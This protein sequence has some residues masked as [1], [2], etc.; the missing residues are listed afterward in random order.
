MNVVAL[1]P[2]SANP[3]IIKALVA[4]SKQIRSMLALRLANI[5][6]AIGEDDLILAMSDGKPICAEQLCRKIGIS[7][8]TLHRVIQ[9]LVARGY[10]EPAERPLFRLSRKGNESV[11]HI[12][13]LRVQIA[14]E[15][16]AMIGVDGIEK[17]CEFLETIEAGFSHFL[18]P[19]L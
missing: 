2:S 15:I 1:K 17:L 7:Q 16:D 11:G 14:S 10:V 5:G 18:R 3:R 4:V 6:L 12:E 8:Q 19:T 13:A 9:D